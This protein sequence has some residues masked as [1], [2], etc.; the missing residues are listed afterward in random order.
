MVFASSCKTET[1]LYNGALVA[2]YAPLTIGKYITYNLDSTVFLNLGRVKEVHSY[3]VKYLV[4]AQITDNLGRPAFR[5]FRF[6]R[7]A[8]NEAWLTDNTFL[9]VNT[10]NGYEFI[11]N[12]QRY[13]KLSLPIKNGVIW[14]G[15]THIDTESLN[16][17]FRYLSG[18]KYTYANVGEPLSLG[19]KNFDNTITINQA[20]EIAGDPSP[21]PVNFS[22]VIFGQEKYAKGIGLV[23]R[24]TTHTTFQPGS[25][26]FYEDGSFSVTYTAIDYN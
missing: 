7:K 12:N 19:S 4:D 3:Q 26:G 17:P 14:N 25:G 10:G 16:S 8:A 20:D 24:K 23:Y 21:N 15:N 11:E 2:D 18:W 1:E 5:I 13:I 22:E 9:A 6:I